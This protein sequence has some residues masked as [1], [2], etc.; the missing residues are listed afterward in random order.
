MDS[1]VATRPIT[2]W[3]AYRDRLNQFVFRSGLVMKP[4][5]ERARRDSKRVV[6]AEGE[7]ERVLRAVQTVV[8]EAS[9]RSRS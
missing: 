3:P 8:D 5:F 1:G 4:I 9:G 2:D 6:Y 7:E